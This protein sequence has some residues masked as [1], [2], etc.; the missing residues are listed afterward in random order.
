MQPFLK[1]LYDGLIPSKTKYFQ[2][3]HKSSYRESVEKKKM[4]LTGD[5]LLWQ[6][7]FGYTGYAIFMNVTCCFTNEI[8]CT[9]QFY[10]G[11]A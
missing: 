10:I 9:T 5:R 8:E 2:E 7:E 4:I 1:W 6:F 11:N 3:R